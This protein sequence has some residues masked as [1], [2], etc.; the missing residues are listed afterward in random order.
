MKTRILASWILMA[1][2]AWA[3]VALL[4]AEFLR[5]GSAWHANQ[6][7]SND[8]LLIFLAAAW[9]L[10]ILLSSWM[11]LDG[12]RGGW[13]LPAIVSK[14]FLAVSC[15]MIVLASLGYGLQQ[16]VSRL[17]LSYFG[18]LLLV[19]F[20]VVRL[21]ARTLLRRRY[22]RGEVSRVV[23]AGSGR[24]A[25]ELATKIA[26]HPEMLCKVAGFLWPHDSTTE[27]ADLA[28]S[29]LRPTPALSTL[30][31][32]ELLHAQKVDEL[33]LALPRP[34]WSEVLNLAGLCRERGIK[35]SLIPQPYELYLS[36]PT[37]IDLDGLPLLQ[38]REPFASIPALYAKRVVD[39]ALGLLLTI[40]T[41]PIVLVLALL[42]RHRRGRAFERVSRC[43]EFGK[44]FHMFRLNVP[45]GVP[46]GLLLERVL[47]RLSVSEL[48]QLW[49]VLR[50][51]MSLVGPRPES[52]DRVK[53]YS[54]WQQE[55]LS[56]KP[57]M[58][59]LAQVHGLREQN[60][61]E[62]KTRFDLQ[63]RLNPS[64][65]TDISLL[66]QTVWTLALRVLSYSQLMAAEPAAS[67]LGE[68]P[69]VPEPES[70]RETPHELLEEVVPSAHRAQPSAN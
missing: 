19:G 61:S 17:A 55:R 18:G 27:Q 16:F 24:V 5:Y 32:V 69:G 11:Q 47:E 37:L 12:F 10:W 7:F 29:G 52:L 6:R 21:G 39:V 22:Q 4:G 60:S 45:R 53:H 31:I 42:L 49:N 35:V 43:G 57:G 68:T 20:V 34:A 46:D 30:G 26:R 36:Q 28:P 3:A 50:G 66:L 33:V 14:M 63:Y 62:E 1:D 41:L 8:G 64:P 58:T 54:E 67:E 59:G 2:L 56:V 15:L 70:M 65:L 51:D 25:R 48:P 40:A 23:I 44:P 9:I 13:H 38:L